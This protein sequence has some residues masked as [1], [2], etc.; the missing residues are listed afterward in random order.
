MLESADNVRNLI[1]EA[2]RVFFEEKKSIERMQL[3]VYQELL[4]LLTNENFFIPLLTSVSKEIVG[5]FCLQSRIAIHA[6]FCSPGKFIDAP[7]FFK[8]RF[9]S[10]GLPN[11]SKAFDTNASQSL[12][13]AVS[14][15]VKTMVRVQMDAVGWKC[16]WTDT[17]FCFQECNEFKLVQDAL[18]LGSLFKLVDTEEEINQIKASRLCRADDSVDV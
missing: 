8:I 10:T 2:E 3:N 12:T 9:T 11:V 4:D 15:Y 1:T 7:G 16:W 17:H 14:S 13:M 5:R 18:R 6:T